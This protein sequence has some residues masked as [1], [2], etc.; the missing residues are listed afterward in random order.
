MDWIDLKIRRIMR[1]PDLG[2]ETNIDIIKA[3][4]GKKYTC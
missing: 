3:F 4:W 2:D 1:R